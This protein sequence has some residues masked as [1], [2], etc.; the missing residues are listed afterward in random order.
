MGDSSPEAAGLVVWVEGG[1]LGILAAV[2]AG[3]AGILDSPVEEEGTPDLGRERSLASG[4]DTGGKALAFRAEPGM[5]LQRTGW[6]AAEA[7]LRT[8]RPG[9]SWPAMVK[10]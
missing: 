3:T 4:T 2:A 6:L 8:G 10:K 5:G 7:S 9:L 1:T